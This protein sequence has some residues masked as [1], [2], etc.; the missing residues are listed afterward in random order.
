M[1]TPGFLPCPDC[2]KSY[3]DLVMHMSLHSCEAHEPAVINRPPAGAQPINEDATGALSFAVLV[4]QDALREEL[5]AAML[6]ARYEHG[7]DNTDIEIT[8]TITKVCVAHILGNAHLRLGP[9][10]K[11]GT[12][13][14]QV[15]EALGNMASVFDGLDTKAQEMRHA[16]ASVPYIKPRE[17]KID[18]ECTVT[19]LD[20]FDLIKRRLQNDA[21][22]RK[23]VMDKSDVWK[24]GNKWRQPPVKLADMDDG[25][26]ARFHPHLMRPATEEE[27]DDVRFAFL[28]NADDIEVVRQALGSARGKHKACGVQTAVLNLPASERFNQDEILMPVLAKASVYKKHGMARVLCGVDAMGKQHD[29]PN[30]ALDMRRLDEGRWCVIPDDVNGGTM[31]VRLKAWDLAFAGDM[32]G[33]N[34]VLPFCE[35]TGAF[36]YCRACDFDRRSPLAGR[37]FSFLRRCGHVGNESKRARTDAPK[38][39]DWQVEG[40]A[41]N[42]MLMRSTPRTLLPPPLLSL[43]FSPL[44]LS[45]T[46]S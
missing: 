6:D 24:L 44:S 12:S 32:L 23:K 8:K 39:R 46:L 31:R 45:L 1:G 2:G 26:A 40:L 41:E 19:S 30:N 33:C 22:W 34:S 10:L 20:P 43:S 37:P 14:S 15:A 36:K 16:T 28:K 38:M 11:P 29:E 35:T 27:K 18:D 21:V 4:S 17:V 25:V 42:A 9:L 13:A 5:S 3:K 7:F